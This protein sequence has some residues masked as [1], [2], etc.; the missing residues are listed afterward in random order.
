MGLII[1]SPNDTL[2]SDN[3]ALMHQV[4]AIDSNAP[5]QSLIAGSTGD[6]YTVPVTNYG[7]I[8]TIIGCSV[9]TQ[10]YILYKKIGKLVFVNFGFTGTSNAITFS[11]T[12][13]YA[14]S[15]ASSQLMNS[16]MI[17]IDN[18]ILGMGFTQ[19]NPSDNTVILFKDIN[20][21]DDE[22]TNSGIKSA[23]GNFW[24]NT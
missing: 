20:S 14:I 8:S 17:S 10:K 18:G 23:S 6:I 12:L 3:H 11:F 19:I 13:P 2:A 5:Q 4:F 24:Y 21:G 22:W 1:P 9:F 16:I 15:N 7:T